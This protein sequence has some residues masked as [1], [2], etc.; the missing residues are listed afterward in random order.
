MEYIQE[1]LEQNAQLQQ[2][3]YQ[4][5]QQAQ[6]RKTRIY[7]MVGHHTNRALGLDDGNATST[8][9]AAETTNVNHRLTT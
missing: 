5:Y 3:L 7:H 8:T 2:Q 9:S 4:N 1:L 6:Q